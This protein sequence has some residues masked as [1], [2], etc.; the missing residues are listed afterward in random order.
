MQPRIALLNV[1]SE[2]SAYLNYAGRNKGSYMCS[3]FWDNEIGYYC[4]TC[5]HNLMIA[6]C[7]LCDHCELC[8]E[9]INCRHLYNCDFCEACDNCSDSKYLFDCRNCQNCIGCADI[10]FK[11]YCIFNEQ[12]SKEEYKRI[13][14]GLTATKIEEK[15]MELKVSVPRR[16]SFQRQSENSFGD[17]LFYS[18]NCCGCYNVRNCEDVLHCHDTYDS[19]DCVDCIYNIN[20]QDSYELTGAI[21][22]Y[23]CKF[24]VINF[25]SHDLTYC[26]YVFNSHHCF[27]CISRNHAK[28]EILNKKY[29]PSEWKRRVFEIEAELRSKGGYGKMP[30]SVYDL[31]DTSGAILAPI[32]YG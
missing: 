14:A 31:G 13:S 3:S 32:Y 24:G 1:N 21:D 12:Y 5:Y 29:E 8:Y 10:Q 26:E 27:G 6:D 17:L 7:D 16:F 2:D 20:V 15:F 28:Y 4:F 18:K 19:K 9:C 23:N 22:S 30:D 11:Q 25:F